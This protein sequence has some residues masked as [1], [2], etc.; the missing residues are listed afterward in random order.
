MRAIVQEI[1]VL[2]LRLRRLLAEH[3][4]DFALTV[5][6]IELLVRA[7]GAAGKLT[8]DDSN[9]VLDRLYAELAASW[10]SSPRRVA[11]LSCDGARRYSR[12]GGGATA[13][14]GR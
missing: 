11:A 3:P 4:E 13:K 9:E 14:L 12:R 10:R 6:T 7:V 1:A 5:R 2:R 8:T